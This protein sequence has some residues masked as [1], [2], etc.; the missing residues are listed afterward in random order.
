MD[1][2]H[3]WQGQCLKYRGQGSGKVY[4]IFLHSNNKQCQKI[5]NNKEEEEEKNMRTG[6]P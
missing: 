2:K 3:D 4:V 5:V 6:M 1:S